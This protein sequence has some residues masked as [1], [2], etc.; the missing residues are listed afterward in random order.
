MS[1]AREIATRVL[2]RVVSDDA[3]AA[4]VL[5][6]EL[7]RADLDPRD[8]AL[9]TQIVYGSLRCLPALDAAYLPFV[10]KGA[11]S[12]DAFVEAALRVATF[13][14]LHLSRVPP[15]AAV[16]AA[17]GSVQRAR[18]KAPSGFVNAVLRKVAKARP[19]DPAPPT[20]LVTKRWVDKSLRAAVGEERARAFLEARPLPPP[21]DLRVSASADMPEL[22]RR[23]EAARPGASIVTGTLLPRCLRLKG[24]GDPRTLPGYV[25][26]LFAVQEQGSQLVAAAL[27]VQ[28]GDRVADICSGRGGKTLALAEALGS[29]GEVTAIDVH[30]ARLE[31]IDAERARLGLRRGCV[32]IECIDL[33]VGAGGLESFDRVLVDAP[34]TG[35]GTVH[36]RPEL[37]LR[38]GKSDPVRMGKIQLAILERAASLVRP[39]GR[40]VYSVCSPTLEEGPRVI[41]AALEHMGDFRVTTA[42]ALPGVE[43]D[44]D[45]IARLGPWLGGAGAATDA[46]QVVCFKRLTKRDSE[47]RFRPL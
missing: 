41:E 20:A 14:L 40:L 35:L 31:Q 37:L 45:G 42:E 28:P 30:E 2:L 21:I 16:D 32:S 36:R 12:L 19:Q 39:G 23:I 22:A 15:H 46:Y 43:V 44:S 7:G 34:C 13:Q 10:R 38:L 11:S 25:E 17:V 24:A 5:D 33:T 4:P 8:A 6:A 18:G 1:D 29:E 27:D 26:G 9:A 47:A 3:F